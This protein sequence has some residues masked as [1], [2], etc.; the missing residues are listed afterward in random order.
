MTNLYYDFAQN[1]DGGSTEFL[2]DLESPCK[3]SEIIVY[4]RRF[5]CRDRYSDMNA[6][7]NDHQC[8]PVAQFDG[9]YVGDNLDSGLKFLCSSFDLGTAVKVSTPEDVANQIVELEVY[10]ETLVCEQN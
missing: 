1:S 2:A 10:C 4:P 8:Q 6:Y 3:V 9:A 7:I 5:C